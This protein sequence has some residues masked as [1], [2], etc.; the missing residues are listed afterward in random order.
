M[1]GSRSSGKSSRRSMSNL[2][3]GRL[4][5]VFGATRE[6]G[7]GSICMGTVF[8]W[9]D[10][11]ESSRRGSSRSTENPNPG[12]DM[13]IWTVALLMRSKASR[14]AS[15]GGHF[16]IRSPRTDVAARTVKSKSS[17]VCDELNTAA[18]CNEKGEQSYQT[19]S[20]GR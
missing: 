16:S 17:R 13:H 1:P 18:D 10:V 2:G 12:V 6:G 5:I 20:N 15:A 11:R 4:R 3:G 8:G 19:R 14:H 9:L 7:Y